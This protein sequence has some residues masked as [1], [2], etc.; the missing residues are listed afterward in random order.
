MLA[1]MQ[2]LSADARIIGIVGG[3]GPHAHVEFERLLLSEAAALRGR[4]LGDQDYP[5]WVLSSIPQTPD[6]TA[7]LLDGG[8]SPVPALLTSLARLARADAAFAAI[9]CNT[10]HAYLAELRARAS[11]PI[12]DMID[13][14]LET[15]RSAAPARVGLLATTG[16]LRARVYH[17]RAQ[18]G[19]PI[20]SLLDLEDGARL[21][22]ELVMAAIYG[23]VVDG[24]RQGGIK[25]GI[26]DGAPRTRLEEA[27]TRLVDAGA[28]RVIL[29]CT[30][31]PL[32][33]GRA[34]VCGA[35]LAD[36]LQALV[37]ASVAI[38][39]GDA[40]LPS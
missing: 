3:L 1:A 11:I 4:P 8:A 34:E 24:R 26:V 38:A 16:T 28:S 12:L 33:L 32:C 29:G 40:P 20:V 22:E 6:R 39:R 37:R 23:P 30:E 2:E 13:L 5:A 14:T 7:A 35:T 10:A 15:V 9:P 27:V 19:L 25:A 21:Q 36:P 31:L 18:A 17:D